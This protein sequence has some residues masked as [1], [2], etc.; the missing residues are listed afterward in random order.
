M[1]YDVYEFVSISSDVREFEFFSVGPNGEIPM[2]IHF[3]ESPDEKV[4]QLSF[5]NKMQDGGLDDEVKNS[6]M[7]RNKIL[8]TVASA[9]FKHTEAFPDKIVVF[10]GSTES[11]TRLYR[12]ALT[13]NFDELQNN[14]EIYGLKLIGLRL[15]MEKFKK[16]KFYI[17]F[18][19]KRKINK[20][21]S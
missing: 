4:I 5:G 17:G 13:L 21:Q 8:A 6:N 20:L 9:V 7:D 1:K 18:G 14:F 16:E 15:C 10:S 3:S 2:V 19:V 11:R 12:M